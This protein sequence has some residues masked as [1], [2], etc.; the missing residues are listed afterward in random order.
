MKK[1]FM[2][3]IMA[4]AAVCANAEGFY[5]GGSVGFWH[6]SDDEQATNQLTVLPEFGYGLTEKIAVGTE[7]GYDYTHLCGM[8]TSVSLFEFNPYVRYT[9][10]KSDDDFVNLFVDGTVGV[11]AGWADFDGDKSDT[12]VTYQVGLR[13]GLSLNFSEHFSFVTHVGMLGY[14]GANNAARLAGYKSEGGLLLNGNALTFGFY[15][16]F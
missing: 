2:C 16:T 7:L 5:V 15:Y 13:P 9:F 4:L 11:G 6:Q 12:A 8:K 10:F 14:K 1:I 3:A